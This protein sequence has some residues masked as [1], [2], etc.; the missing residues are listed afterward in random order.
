MKNRIE[1]LSAAFFDATI[2]PEEC[3]ELH[4]L[5]SEQENLTREQQ[6][7]KLMLI[8]F[9]ELAKEHENEATEKKR[10]TRYARIIRLT[11]TLCSAAAIIAIGLFVAFSPSP[12][13]E[14]EAEIL[15]YINGEPITDV[16]IAM[17]QLK[18]FSHLDK[19]AQTIN[20]FE[21]ITK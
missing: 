16:N 21:S 18:Y 8:G 3:R 11:A 1:R 7:L 14:T 19:L 9:T 12:Q 10:P 4:T 5:L 2:T 17:E 20:R 15:C 6:A 13:A